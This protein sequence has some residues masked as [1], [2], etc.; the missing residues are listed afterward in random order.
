MTAEQEG[1][2]VQVRA[3][4]GRSTVVKLPPGGSVRDLKAAL[5]TSFPP[6]QVAPSFHL[7]LKGAKLR[8]D[9]EIGSLAISDGEFIVLV[10]FTRTPQQCSSVCT[11][12]QEQGLNPPK[13]PEVSSAAN[14]AWKDIMDDLSAMPTSPQSDAASKDFYSCDPCSGR[15][16]EPMT[17]GQ[18]S[19]SGPSRKRRKTCKEN[20]N[21]SSQMVSSEVNG[22]A[23]K[24]NISKKSGVA[25]SAATSC[26]D[27]HPLEPAEMVEHLKQ[28]LGKEEQIVH[29]QEIQSR[30]ASFTELPCNLS[31]AM[32]EALKSIGISRLYSHQSQAIKSSISGRHIVVAT[33]TS[34]GKSLCYNIPVLESL[35][36]DSMACA[37]YIFPTKA[38]A[39][40]QLR[41]LLEMKNASHIDIDV[42]IYDGDTPREDRLWIRDNARLLITN[43]DMLHVSILPY[44]GQFQR[45]LSNLRYIVIDEAHSYKGAFGCH[46]A[47]IIQRLKRICSNGPKGLQFTLRRCGRL[48]CIP[49][50]LDLAAIAIPT[51]RGGAGIS[52]KELANLDEVELIQNDG[53]PCGSKYFLLWNPPLHMTEGRS[54][55]SSVPRR[56]RREILQETAKE[57]VDSICVYRAGYI[58]E[59]RRKIEADLFGGK[60]R[61][62]A[63]TNALELGIDVGHIDATLHLGFP[64]SIASL[65]QQ[66][67]RSGRRAKQSLAIYVAFEGPLDQYFMKFPH[68]L[69]G[70]PIEHC[71]VDSHNLKVLGQ[72]LACAAY[73]HPLCLQYDECY[74]GSTLDRVMTTLKDKGYIINNRAGSFCSSMWNYIGPERSPSQAV[75]IRAIEQDKYKVI[76]KLNNRLLEEIE[77]SKAFFQVYEGAVY[78]HQG[79]NYLVEELDL[80]SRTAFCRKA[81][82]KY[83][84]KTRDY[85][86][87]NVLGG[88]F[89]YLPTSTCKTDRVKTTAQANDCTVTTK[90]FGFYRIS[91]S[92]NK[93]SD[94]LELNLPPYSFISQAVWVRIP[95]SV[96]I[97]VEERKLEFRSGSHA[98]SHALLNVVP[99]HM[100]CSAS[101]LGTE[102]ANPHETRGI[103]DRILLYDRHPGGIGIVSQAQMLFGE[104][105]LAALELVSTCNCTSAVGC[106]NCIQS[107]TCSEYNEVLDKEASILILKGVIDYERSY[108]EAEDASQRS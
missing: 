85:T 92:S 108:F 65:W 51:T 7:F 31:K 49:G 95:H 22:T 44:H 18:S 101:D 32:R 58:A 10:P 8:L 11:A 86:D 73:E 9:S 96:K 21:G 33:S 62:V 61:G 56:S 4:D 89:A 54:K 81:D 102:C 87:I 82:L 14:S 99:L 107:L 71:Q 38:L 69:F 80:A 74:F 104:L 46:T 68:K 50:G 45:I 43:P 39:Q 76:D 94:S 12:S 72:H 78:M 100:M 70:R 97:T 40:D 13:Q 28:G 66:A 105:L 23:E 79:V 64:G 57:L 67:G 29:I 53:S 37:L 98:A 52:I 60:L 88:E 63:A 35:S 75:S 36:Q 41:T 24:D 26:H 83:Y 17:V 2:E 106:P 34:S 84:T 6:A 1:R 42:K 16:T 93:I 3:L 30:E 20:G 48:L 103:P 19:S 77:E 91:K 15:F 5:R 55:A 27:M 90:W 25:K 47:L 59:D